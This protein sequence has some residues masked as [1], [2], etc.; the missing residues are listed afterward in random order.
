MKYLSIL[1]SLLLCGLFNFAPC[2]YSA[3]GAESGEALSVED[4]IR[5]ALDRNKDLEAIDSRVLQARARIIKARAAFK[6]RLGFDFAYL[7]GDAPS[8]YLFK[9]IDARELPAGVDF[10]HP[11]IFE[12][13][14]AGLTSQYK[15]WDGGR[16]ELR[17]EITRL[18]L[19]AKKKE[20]DVLV[21][22]LIGTVIETYFDVLAAEEFLEV[23][24]SSLETVKEQLR[25]ARVRYKLGGALETDVLSL[26]VREAQSRERLISSQNAVELAKAG[27]RRLLNMN[28]EEP[29]ELSGEEWKPASFPQ[30]LTARISEALQH[31]PEMM[32]LKERIHSSAKAHLLS[33]KGDLPSLDLVGRYYMDDKGGDFEGSRANW[34]IGAQVSWPIFDGGQRRGS[35]R[36]AK[37][38]HK[39]LLAKKASLKRRIEM[40]VQQAHL[41]LEEAKARLEVARANS[42]RARRTLDLVKKQ[43]EAGAASVTRYLGAQTDGTRAQ[44][45]AIKA[46]Y[47]VKKA[48]AGLGH[49][50]GL[51]V[52]CTKEWKS[53]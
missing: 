36:E 1:V 29:V 25:E 43:F 47:D 45:R 16:K 33:K 44:F 51:C 2:A 19:S 7:K 48:K 22:T 10:N 46:R 53:Q 37:E 17:L 3:L 52:R 49:V 5:I 39:E 20:R 11:G 41:Q 38:K 24:Q 34:T 26:E 4:S 42:K 35:Q 27:F 12:N 23:A 30:S 6:P 18:G 21:N 40:E 14:E 9:R 8:A 15:L 31:R 13:L 32:V 28:P 50:L